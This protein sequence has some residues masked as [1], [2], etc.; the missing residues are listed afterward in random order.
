MDGWASKLFQAEDSVHS[1]T[2]KVKTNPLGD[3][4]RTARAGTYLN[5]LAQAEGQRLVVDLPESACNALEKLM[6]S[7]YGDT[8]RAVVI[9]ALLAASKD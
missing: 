5:R 1:V 3:T 7:G 9:R 2:A 8:K 4:T 6:N